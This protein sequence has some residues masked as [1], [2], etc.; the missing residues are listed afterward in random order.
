ME[1]KNFEKQPEVIAYKTHG[2]EGANL[3][4]NILDI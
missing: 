2:N 3:V 1:E 4:R